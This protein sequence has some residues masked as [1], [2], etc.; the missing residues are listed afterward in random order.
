M[1]TIKIFG[2]ALM[3]TFGV[4]LTSC[5]SDD[6]GGSLPDIDGYGSADEV[7]ETDLVAHFGLDGDG[8]ESM[9]GTAPTSSPN[10]TWVDGIK[11]KAANF[12]NGYMKYPSMASFPASMTSFTISGWVKVKNNQTPTS[13]S[14][15]TIFSMARPNE[16][17]GN[18]NLYVE[19][20][21]SPA[22]TDEGVAN[23]SL[24][25][26]GS[27]RTAAD[28]GQAY[29]NVL[30]LEPWMVS[31]NEVTPGKH[32][33]GPNVVG[34]TW[35]HAVFTWDGATNKFIVYSNGQKISN[36]AFEIRGENTSLTFDTPTFPMIGA[37]GN[38]DTTA[39]SWNKAM[40]GQVDEIRV[41]KRALTLAEIGALYQLEKAGR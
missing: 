12:N 14:V 8:E 28:G 10:T 31:D 21:Q 5:G 25:F 7:G 9:S 15:S 26:K 1:K 35:A 13:G 2:F 36:P 4:L 33:A 17:E 6:E 30:H 16:W 29:E 34:G 11:G 23:D 41:W 22:M 19:T 38:V 24:I 39:D 27:W 37:F 32:V 40:T 18:M 20:G 3:A